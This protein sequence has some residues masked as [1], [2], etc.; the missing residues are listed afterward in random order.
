MMSYYGYLNS[1]VHVYK[2]ILL[3]TTGKTE[4]TTL[5]S[6]T[7]NE[8]LKDIESDGEDMDACLLSR[9]EKERSREVEMTS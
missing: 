6:S 1:N 8:I 9:L 4:E 3:R 7:G 2:A 5:N